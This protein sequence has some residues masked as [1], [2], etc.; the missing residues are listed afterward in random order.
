MRLGELARHGSSCAR[1]VRS[2]TARPA[3]SA[4]TRMHSEIDIDIDAPPALVFAW[5]VTSSAG[6][7]C[8]PTTPVARRRAAARRRLVADFVARRPLVPRP[9]ASGCRS[10]WRSR[11]W[12]EPADAPAAVRPRRGRDA[13]HGRH[14]ADRATDRRWDHAGDRS[15]TTSTRALPVLARLVDR[16]FTRPIAGR[17]LAT[18]KAIA[19]AVRPIAS[20]T[21]RPA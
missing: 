20:A 8:C 16:W 6:P 21:N 2:A 15:S 19:E 14:L 17:T 5:P 11:T 12:N 1:P 13:G 18:F 3:A 4:L 9:R 7:T 10:T